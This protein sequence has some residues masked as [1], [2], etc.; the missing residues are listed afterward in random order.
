LV[1]NWRFVSVEL[2]LTNVAGQ[3]YDVVNNPKSKQKRS[4]SL[5]HTRY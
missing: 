2:W 4:R 1:A 5:G 3:L